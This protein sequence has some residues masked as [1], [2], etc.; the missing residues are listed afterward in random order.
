MKNKNVF[1]ILLIG[2]IALYLVWA[3]IKSHTNKVIPKENI[4]SVSTAKNTSQNAIFNISDDPDKLIEIK[5]E[6]INNQERYIVTGWINT[7][8]IDVGISSIKL[9]LF[10]FNHLVGC[11]AINMDIPRDKVYLIK[12]NEEKPITKLDVNNWQNDQWINYQVYAQVEKKSVIERVFEQLLADEAQASCITTENLKNVE[13]IVF[14]M[15]VAKEKQTIE[16]TAIYK[17]YQWQ[18]DMY[19]IVVPKENQN[20]NLLIKDD[21]KNVDDFL[22]NQP[23]FRS[24]SF[25]DINKFVRLANNELLNIRNIESTLPF[26][27]FK[28]YTL[29]GRSYCSKFNQYCLFGIEKLIVNTTLERDGETIV[30]DLEDTFNT[31]YHIF[32]NKLLLYKDKGRLD[33][34]DFKP[35]SL[36][37]NM[38]NVFNNPKYNINIEEKDGYK[39][40][41]GNLY[42]KGTIVCNINTEKPD[43]SC[44]VEPAI[45]E[46]R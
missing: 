43:L 37:I 9:A 23:F 22:P 34:L 18:T 45:I 32:N 15:P 21:E 24:I 13:K 35:K 38:K 14:Q 11:L 46:T 27:V 20:L 25:Y 40:I 28:D 31:E 17:N 4:V 30:A 7:K 10:P 42:V 1:S 16:A 19:T 36:T 39:Y 12:D 2:S 33:F 6:L 41:T 44:M 29:E 26:S 8:D 3:N 5:K